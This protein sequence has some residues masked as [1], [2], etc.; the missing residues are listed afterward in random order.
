MSTWR[1]THL[2]VEVADVH[3]EVPHLHVEVADHEV[4]VADVHV[5]VPHLHVGTR[6][7]VPV[8]DRRRHAAGLGVGGAVDAGRRQL[9]GRVVADVD[10]LRR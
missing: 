5:E 4:E 3:V 1:S 8:R 2:E 9:D 7:A 10:G 6:S